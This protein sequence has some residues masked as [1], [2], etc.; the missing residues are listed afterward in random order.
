MNTESPAVRVAE[1][2]EQGYP[3]MV[4]G[5]I[6]STS[7]STGGAA[8]RLLL[9]TAGCNVRG[10]DDKLPRV[11]HPTGL[12]FGGSRA[13][14]VVLG[15]FG[16]LAASAALCFL[17]LQFAQA[18][19]QRAFP[20]LFEGLDTQGFVRIPS[21]PLMVFTFLYQ[22]TTYGAVMLLME[23]PDPVGFCVGFAAFVFCSAVPVGIAFRVQRAVPAKAVYLRDS[24][25]KGRVW[26]FLIG[27]GEWVSVRRANHWVNRY[28]S[29]VR[30]YRQETVLFSLIEYG[31]MFSLAAVSAARV[32]GPFAC[33]HVKLFSGFVFL[34]QL[35]AEAAL[36][37]HER[38]RNNVFDFVFLAC[39]AAGLLCM[40]AGFYLGD[41]HHWSHRAAEVFFWTA[42]GTLAVRVLCDL[43]TE[44]FVLVKGRRDRLQ[45]KA[46][47]LGE[48]GRDGQELLETGKRDDAGRVTVDN[49]SDSKHSRPSTLKGRGAGRGGVRPSG[50][51]FQ[52][53]GRGG[54]HSSFDTGAGSR[55]ESAA[56]KRKSGTW[57]SFPNSS[58]NEGPVSPLLPG[59]FG[60]SFDTCDGN[61][62][63]SAGSK[64]KSV[65]LEPFPNS[66]TNEGPVSPLSPGGNHSS[67]DTFA[68]NRKG[69]AN[70][71]KS[72][73]LEP[74][75]NS[76]TNEGQVSLLSPG[77]NHSGFDTF[78]CNRRGSAGSS[79]RKSVTLEPFPNSPT[80]E[81]PVSPLSPGGNRS[82]F[83]AYYGS[84][85]G[86]AR[87]N[88]KSVTL[89]PFLNSPTNEG[90]VSP[91][92]Q[93]GNSPFAC[94]RRES[95][96][97]QRKSIPF[98]SFPN[99]P[100]SGGP[101][102]PR[103]LREHGSSF[104]TLDARGPVEFCGSGSFCA[105]GNDAPT[106]AIDTHETDTS[107]RLFIPPPGQ[108]TRSS[109][110]DCDLQ[111]EASRLCS[112]GAVGVSMNPHAATNRKKSKRRNVQPLTP[113]DSPLFHG[114]TSSAQSPL[115]PT[116][117]A[118]SASTLRISSPS[119]ALA[120]SQQNR[121]RS[122]APN[123]NKA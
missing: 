86:S 72:V 65:T 9:I 82:S 106:W 43:L 36:L 64:R 41:V 60:S 100:A 80:N 33:G 63:G 81:G 90:P 38:G 51:S 123:N 56:G 24:V 35:V 5:S 70:K 69:S 32:E 29:V 30:T 68:C 94:S 73:T 12:F 111:L 119:D 50:G 25:Y 78:A 15:N 116:F 85:R 27:P 107:P 7:A 58:T 118:G 67:F 37:P 103:W 44:L 48:A 34:V 1:R 6:V 96:G 22:G 102:S 84:R 101:V 4:A 74:F 92:L 59:G 76:P 42:W 40:A 99:S 18:A 121:R 20:T 91:L 108:A 23:P 71:R 114:T 13:L 79:K 46:F 105:P 89:E 8:S 110:A 87:G 122:V 45:N 10:A 49:A 14:W 112:S 115:S 16:L 95:A 61:R 109:P 11:F 88:R 31:S 3:A 54:N 77:G 2:A 120:H 47:G 75:L 26:S 83:D 113:V 93:G 19:G 62:R 21:A 97:G 104:D 98:G 55:R 66:P 53:N 39:Q 17:L 117:S 57:E 52:A 28:A